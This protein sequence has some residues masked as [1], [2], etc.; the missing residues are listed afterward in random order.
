MRFYLIIM[1]F[2][3]LTLTGVA[4][5]TV[6]LRPI[7]EAFITEL[8]TFIEDTMAQYNVPGAAVAIVQGGEVV[9]TGGFGIHG[10]ED[11]RPVTPQTLFAV[12][13]VT[14]SMTAMM[15]A[16]LVDEGLLEWD[17]PVVEVMPQFT[18]TADITLRHLLSHTSGLML[19]PALFLGADLPP[20]D[21][22]RILAFSPLSEPGTDWRYHNQAY[23]LGAY[24]GV[25]AAGYDF[26]DNLVAAYRD[27]MQARVFDPTGM[28][29][30]LLD[31][32]ESHPDRAL[33]TSLNLAGGE[34]VYYTPPPFREV[35]DTP[36]S[37][38]QSNAEDMAA[39]L[40]AL[41]DYDGT[42][43]LQ[44]TWE[45]VFDFDPLP[46]LFDS[47]AYGMGWYNDTFRD[48]HLITHSGRVTG[49]AASVAFLPDD[50]TGIV[51]LC[52]A[53]YG[54][55]SEVTQHH[56]IELLHNLPPLY[57]TVAMR[58]YDFQV[59]EL[60]REMRW[61]EAIDPVVVAPRLGT[62]DNGRGNPIRLEL[63]DGTLW[64][65][66][67]NIEVQLMQVDDAIYRSTNGLFSWVVLMF[68]A[69]DD[70]VIDGVAFPKVVD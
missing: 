44:D 70:L 24:M 56:F 8:E 11:Q 52:N 32:D 55:L 30:T 38:A 5:E 54:V 68:N 21:Y 28:A 12:G 41:L 20:Q 10:L 43:S 48:I 3:T 27:L 9:Y 69:V 29:S 40:L 35:S 46:R 51:I 23:A 34:V 4:Q 14:K 47:S 18:G 58:D 64:S 39:Y 62:Y 49:F 6:D 36:A 25:L 17:T 57:A 65:V 16:S 33:P 60:L 66:R 63:R 13:S 7:D 37:M 42:G 26:E 31:V 22:A 45:P 53:D 1:V 50:D 19:S 67:G 15:I 59:D 2:F 61:L